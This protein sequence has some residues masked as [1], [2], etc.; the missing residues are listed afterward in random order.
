MNVRFRSLLARAEALPDDQ[1]E[2]LADLMELFMAGED[3][4]LVS[5]E[6]LEELKRIEAEPDDLAD[7][8]EVAA[9]LGRRG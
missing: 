5:P 3:G 1:Q 8:A 6:E 9:V 7:P 2:G 4:D